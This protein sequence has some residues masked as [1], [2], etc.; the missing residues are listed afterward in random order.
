MKRI[1]LLFLLAIVSNSCAKKSVVA[2]FSPNTNFSE[3]RDYEAEIPHMKKE[4]STSNPIS[5]EVEQN[6]TSMLA[7]ATPV[8]SKTQQKIADLHVD[9]ILHAAPVQSYIQKA[10]YRKQSPAPRGARN[11]APQL[12]IGLTLLAIGVVLAVFGLGFVGGLSAL[13]GLLFTIVG[14]LVSY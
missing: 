4:V 13:I 9:R 6:E 11:W 7:V 8:A 5:Q 10:S 12:K 3:Q 1:L 14:L 2:A